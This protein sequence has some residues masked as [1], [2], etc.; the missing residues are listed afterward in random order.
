M[1]HETITVS[2][3]VCGSDEHGSLLEV[4]DRWLGLPGSF[5]YARCTSCGLVYLRRRPAAEDL[6]DYYPPRYI[7]RGRGP[8]WMHRL[9]R[10]LDLRPRVALTLAQPGHRVL[11]VGCSTGEFLD[12]VRAQRRVVAGVEPSEWASAAAA[13]RGL[14]V[15]PSTVSDARLPQG[16][17]DVV[18]MWDVIEHL[19]DPLGDLVAIRR[20]LRPGGRLLVT[21]PVLDGWEVRAFGHAWPGWDAPRHLT[22]FTQARLGDLLSEAGFR[23]LGRR[24][25]YESYLITA[26]ALSLVARERL[27]RALADVVWTL[28]HARPVRLVMAVP[29]RVLDRALG[30]CWVTFVAESEADA[31]DR[32]S[33]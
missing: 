26:M 6:D 16:A 31:H 29:F 4:T 23:V 19:D 30:G 18:T 7:Q 10:T 14:P 2:C 15:W 17:F 32:G 8:E 11:D 22:L 3:P 28:L 5:S 24:W 20:A 27:P 33:G 25:V 9:F 13:G 1:S 12:Q 21:T